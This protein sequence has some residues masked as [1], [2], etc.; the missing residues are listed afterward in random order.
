MNK[1]ISA[2]QRINKLNPNVQCTAIAERFSTINALG[3]VSS[4]D[5][6]ID[7]TD[8]FETR[9]IIND[10]CVLAKKPFITGSAVG[11]EGQVTMI[12][13]GTT[14]CYRCLYPQ[15][16]M[17]EACRSCANA[18]VLGP[19][20]G[21]IGCLEAI[22]ALKFIAHPLK[23]SSLAG[24]QLFFDGHHSEFMKL[25]FPTA[26]SQCQVC[27]NSPTIHSME[28]TQ[29]FL[30][31]WALQ[32]S[33]ASSAYRG[34]LSDTLQLSMGQFHARY[35]QDSGRHSIIL[36]VRSPVQFG[37]VALQL[38]DTSLFRD[39]TEALTTLQLDESIQRMLINIP[40]R[41]LQ[42]NPHDESL[43]AL[44][45]LRREMHRRSA[46]QGVDIFVVCRRGVDSV[47]ATRLLHEVFG[48][49]QG[50]WNLQGGLQ[51]W[52]QEVDPS[53]PVY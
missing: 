37:M 11:L 47:V 22:E 33:E 26:Q 40:L 36:D 7:A 42:D 30:D 28:D 25:Q 2:V 1:A 27:G 43:E 8:N 16:S 5:L 39:L 21:M 41:T 10:A 46:G 52:S 44:K 15:P 24:S 38:P 6:V 14:P 12:L 34:H 18:G 19:V 23:K 20:P 4:H 45:Q 29:A 49:E 31:E 48:P 32:V 17:G 9:Y 51:A 35:T 50:I 53:F 13:P 3:L